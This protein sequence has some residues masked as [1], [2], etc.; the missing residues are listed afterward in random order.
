M[1]WTEEQYQEYLKNRGKKVEKPKAQKKQKYR[2]KGTWI[3]GVFFRS[4]L[5]AKRYCQLK[6]LFHAG[7]IA[8]FV[9]QPQFILQEGNGENRA[10]TYSS[11]FLVLNKDGS[12]TVEDTKGYE[13][14]QWKRTYKQ[15]KLR[16]PGIDL[17]ILK[18]V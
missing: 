2:N 9:L 16:Y 18:E 15:F 6:L 4:Q 3:D 10:I 5:E 14:E 11:D 13:S 8:G 12:Y 7:E 17:K 1:R